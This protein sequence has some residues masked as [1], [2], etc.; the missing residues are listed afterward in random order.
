MPHPEGLSLIQRFA[1]PLMVV[2]KDKSPQKRL[3]R[4]CPKKGVVPILRY[5]Y[6][7]DQILLRMPHLLPQLMKLLQPLTI[8]FIHR[9]PPV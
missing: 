4:R 7:Y 1:E 9:K 2:A 6:A 8:Y 3:P 5:I